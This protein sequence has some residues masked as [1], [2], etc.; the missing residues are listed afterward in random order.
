VGRFGPYVQLGENDGEGGAKPRMKSLLPGM[1]PEELTLEEALRLLSL[2]R[3]LGNDPGTGEEVLAD[4]GR[5]GPYLRR[6]KET[7]SIPKTDDLFTITLERA[8]AIL[9]E[10]RKG[11]WRSRTPEVLKELGTHPDSNG[12]IKVLSG[13]Y[14]PY[15]SD[16]SHNAKIPEGREPASLTHE[17]AVELI[18]ARAAMGP[19]SKG[20]RKPARA[21]APA[22]GK[23]ASKKAAP[24]TKAKPAVSSAAGPG[25][26]QG[27]DARPTRKRKA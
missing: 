5:F 2:P 27:K 12:S 19:P 6:G 22:A 11:G 23:K 17:E 14:G 20:R 26:A 13:R 4:F 25:S 3:T 7:R 8:A 10:E 18:R 16:G 1:K 9:K 21:M 24:K 15:V